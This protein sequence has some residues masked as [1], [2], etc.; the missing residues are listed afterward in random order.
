LSKTLDYLNTKNWSDEVPEE[1]KDIY[2][3]KK[4]S[5][6]MDYEKTKYKFGSIT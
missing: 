3:Q 2:D 6:S 1:L 5:K 4:Y